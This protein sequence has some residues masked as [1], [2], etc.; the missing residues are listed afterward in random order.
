MW[1][2]I[3]PKQTIIVMCNKN[4]FNYNNLTSLPRMYVNRYLTYKTRNATSRVRQCCNL[5]CKFALKCNSPNEFLI[6]NVS[7]NIY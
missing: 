2:P 3:T 6:G 4:C 5:N 1:F 7:R